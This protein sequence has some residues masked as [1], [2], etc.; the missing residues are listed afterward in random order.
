M[1]ELAV[2][3]IDRSL[4]DARMRYESRQPKA[5]HSA[6]RAVWILEHQI[7]NRAREVV[8]GGVISD[9]LV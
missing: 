6:S 5:R 2:Y 3:L 8:R 4:V 7:F 9:W 1:K